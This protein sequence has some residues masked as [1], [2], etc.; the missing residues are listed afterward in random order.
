MKVMISQPMNGIPD[1]EV[2]KI[3]N[4][5]IEKANKLGITV[6]DSFDTSKVKD[7]KH[8]GVYY[9]GRTIMNHLH[10]VDAVYFAGDW[11][12]AR[13]CRIEFA[14]CQEYGIKILPENFFDDPSPAPIMNTGTKRGE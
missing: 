3:R 10:N 1:S 2:L 5:I 8:P 13:G 9:L 12:A 6:V 14:I 11:R 4:D 7:S